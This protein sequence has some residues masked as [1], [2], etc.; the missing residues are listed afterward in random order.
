M[1]NFLTFAE[2]QTDT[3]KRILYVALILVIIALALLSL[4]GWCL[5]KFTK[6]RGRQLDEEIG[7]AVRSGVI[8]DA[9]EFRRYYPRKNALMFY[10]EAWPAILIIVL[11]TIVYIAYMAVTDNWTYN[12]WSMEEGF[13]SLLFTWDF[14]KIFQVNVNDTVGLLINWPETTHTPVFDINNWCG[15][16]TCTGWIVGAL[17]YIYATIG[18]M[19]RLLRAKEL[20]KQMYSLDNFNLFKQVFESP[21]AQQQTNQPSK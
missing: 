14:S 5:V 20:S 18:L 16:V 6:H 11:A 7:P 2:Q 4:I 19:G 17:W 8:S 15:Y 3:G 21:A 13:G 12:P 10:R 1:Y 9:K